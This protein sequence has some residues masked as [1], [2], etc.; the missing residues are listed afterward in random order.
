MPA[1][2]P[3]RSRDDRDSPYGRPRDDRR[4]GRSRSRSRE[5]DR[6]WGYDRGR[7][8]SPPRRSRTPEQTMSREPRR[9]RSGTRSPPPRDERDRER[10]RPSHNEGQSR[11]LSRSRSPTRRRRSSPTPPGDAPRFRR[12]FSSNYRHPSYHDS[13]QRG[14]DSS[15]GRGSWRGAP[16]SY[17]PR[18][19]YQ[20]PHFDSPHIRVTDAN[21]NP[22]QRTPPSAVPSFQSNQ[23][24]DTMKAVPSTFTD[25]PT[26]DAAVP[27]GP[28]S[29]RRA[30]QYKQERP[31]QTDYRSNYSL[32]RG[33]PQINQLHRN[34]PRQSYPQSPA[35]SPHDPP[36]TSPTFHR[37]S[38][39]TGPRALAR[40]SDTQIK[41]EYISPVADLEE[42]VCRFVASAD[43]KR[44]KLKSDYEKLESKDLEVQK[45]KRAALAEWTLLDRE[46]KR[47]G[48]KVEMTEKLLEATASGSL[49][50]S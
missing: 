31:Y 1:D 9:R 49:F 50:V 16:H 8:Q 44:S 34:S 10:R 35:V 47:E 46:S 2:R 30:Q 27:A 5:R 13:P 18:G 32:G 40:Y 41:K 38:I 43:P 48:A 36:S 12:E 3:E 7:E 37:S 22:P 24:N 39:P 15:R 14:Y 42:Q 11:G 45:R 28:A 20:Q 26:S 29:W 21:N 19:G 23:N 4:R 25:Q 17:T 6:D 33:A